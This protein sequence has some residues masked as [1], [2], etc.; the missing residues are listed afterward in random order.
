MNKNAPNLKGLFLCTVFI[1]SVLLA[2]CQEKN[3]KVEKTGFYFNTVV[4]I[5]L[6]G[7]EA[8]EQIEECFRICE[9]LEQSL[10]RTINTSEIS[11]INNRPAG[12]KQMELGE[13]TAAILRAG[14]FFSEISGG[15]FDITIAPISSLWDFTAEKP[16]VPSKEQIEDA[17]SSVD[18]RNLHLDGN[19]LTFSSDT[20][21][22]DPGAIAK[23]YIA[24]RLNEYLNSQGVKSGYLNL[25]GNVLCIGSKPDGS[26][27]RIGL[28][29][30]FGEQNEAVL[31][32]SVQD[33][34]IVTSGVYERCF[35]SD[36]VFYHHLLNPNTGYPF[37]NGLLSITIISDSSTDGDG[38][39][40]TC[41]ALGLEEGMKLV[42]RTE[43]L[44]AI[45]ITEDEVIHYSDGA[46][47]YVEK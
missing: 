41:F 20:V 2:G 16:Q 7:P 31:V 37:Q 40:T 23:G 46:E 33:K 24:D 44:E 4:S 42:N 27:Y 12:T 35:T 3:Q 18:Y 14:L 8:S 34:S 17:L 13:D 29:K 9:Q 45:F 32:L 39:S 21:Q 6:Y 5:T 1:L 10:S 26:S 28:Q 38:Y 43:G 30:P 22:V 25:G 15:A 11:A 36:G 19:T 47:Q